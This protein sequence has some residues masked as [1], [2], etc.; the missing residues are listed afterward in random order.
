MSVWGDIRKKSLG[1]EMRME[2]YERENKDLKDQIKILNMQVRETR[3]V[4]THL[5]QELVRTKK[6]LENLR[7]KMNFIKGIRP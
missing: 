5:D 6:E 3:A 1:Q 7:H 4:I 2:D